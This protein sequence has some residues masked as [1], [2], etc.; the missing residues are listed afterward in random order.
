MKICHIIHY[1]VIGGAEKYAIYLAQ[2]ARESGHEV[3]FILSGEGELSRYLKKEGY[4]LDF[5]PMPSWYSRK[6]SKEI[7][8]FLKGKDID[9]VHTHHLR[10]HFLATST[11]RISKKVKVVRTFH[12]IDRMPLKVRPFYRFYMK[13][14][15]GVIAIS[16]Y[17]RE[18]LIEKGI[19]KEKITVIK[20]GVPDSNLSE[21]SPGIGFLGRLVSEK[22]ILKFVEKN[23]GSI[24]EKFPLYIAGD[25]PDR[26]EIEDAA[27]KNM[28]IHQLGSIDSPDKLFQK[29]SVLILPS[30][31]EVFPLSILEAFSAGI[32]VIAFELEPLKEIINE[33]N[34]ALIKMSDYGEMF[35]VASQLLSDRDEWQKKSEG[36]RK[37]Y[38]LKYTVDLMWQNTEKFYQKLMTKAS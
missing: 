31:T 24:N 14:T 18:H 33:E 11:K 10:E 21:Y 29:I 36:A 7:G 16:N 12:R 19:Q 5:I 28:N 6:A 9:I 20:N 23:I 38:E 22:G 8:A 17:I 1:P 4:T 27:R 26:E 2:A 32:P 25:G 13:K 37:D 34:G 35:K 30:K 15:D 3:F